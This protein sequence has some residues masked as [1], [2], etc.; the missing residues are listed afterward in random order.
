MRTRQIDRKETLDPYG[1][2]VSR[3]ERGPAKAGPLEGL[4]L[5]VKDNIEVEG[6][7]F[8]AGHPL[9]VDRCGSTTAPAV[10]RLLAA[11]AVM[12]GMTRTDSGG[13]GMTTPDVLNPRFPGHT[14]GGSSGG[15]AA[16]VSAGLADIGLGTDTGGSIRV[17]AACTGLFGFKPSRGRVPV[18]GIWPLAPSFDHAGL[19]ARD[20]ETI[21]RSAEVL[22][23]G[24]EWRADHRTS[25]TS[26]KPLTIVVDRSAPAYEDATVRRGFDGVLAALRRAGHVIKRGEL[27]DPPTIAGFFGALVVAEASRVYAALSI[28]DRLLLGPAA[29]RA[30]ARPL[31]RATL[32]LSRSGLD[33]AAGIYTGVLSDCDVFLSPTMY[34]A[35]P[36]NGV[37]TIDAGGR[38]WNVLQVLL[39][40]TCFGNFTG[41]P[42]LA[43][44][45]DDAFSIHLTVRHG[46]DATLFG[47][48]DRLLEAMA[49]LRTESGDGGRMSGRATPL[50]TGI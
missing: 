48:A 19:L 7:P 45:V 32:D 43:V 29:Q 31:E 44:P 50:T 21:A 42:T 35:P 16:A 11:G 30:L 38:R 33:S 40:G 37:H 4:R 39:S 18:E 47:I 9:F 49:V 2:F 5:C 36:R 27:P 28:A 22:L 12:N 10:G 6:Q 26:S 1:A 25:S 20:L 15:A 8:S 24:D 34:V 46:D 3:C 13:F 23:G 14:V 41:A 17:P